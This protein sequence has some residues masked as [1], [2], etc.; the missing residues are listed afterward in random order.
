MVA[1]YDVKECSK[2]RIFVRMAT[3]LHHTSSVGNHVAYQLTRTGIIHMTNI[4][5]HDNQKTIYLR[6]L[7]VDFLDSPVDLVFEE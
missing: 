4:T 3:T 1:T 7:V 5:K 6:T 2:R